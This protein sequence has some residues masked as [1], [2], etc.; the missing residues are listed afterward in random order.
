[1][2]PLEERLQLSTVNPTAVTLGAGSA[3]DLTRTQTLPLSITLPPSSVTN[4][5]DIALLL[6][7]T[8]SFKQFAGTV[9]SLFSNL[10]SS[11]Q[12]A[13]PGVDLGFGIARFEDYGGP[14]SSVTTENTGGRPFFLDRPIV[15]AAT[16]T[17]AGTDLNT[18]MKNALAATGPGFGG[19]TPEP[20]FEAL[21]Q[22]ATGAGFDGNG[23]GSRLDSGL[24]GD[25]ATSEVNPGSSGD[26]PPFSSNV[27]LT[28]G[29]LGGIGWRPGAEHIVL[30]ATDTAPVAS[31]ATSPIPATVTGLGGVS[32]PSTAFESTAGRVGFDSTVVDGV[33]TGPQPAVEPLGGATVQETVNSL[34]SLGI[35]VIGMG[36][37]AAP[38]SSTAAALDPSTFFSAIGR[39]TGTVD[40]TGQPL[41]FSTSVSTSDL[42]TAIVNSVKTVA[43]QPVDIS[44]SPDSLPAGLS[45][46]PAP[47]VVPKVGPGGTAT[48][49]VT[50]AVGSLP[51]TGTF[52]ASFVDPASGTALG[53]VPFQISLPGPPSQGG[54]PGAPT[55]GDPPGDP[56]S[57]PPKVLSGQRVG[58]HM[59]PA[60]IIITYSEAMDPATVQNVN[61]YVLKGPHG[62][63]VAI[64]SASYDS[65]AHTVTLKPKKHVDFH[66]YYS[67]TINGVGAS[68]VTSAAGVPLD[69]MKTGQPGDSYA[70][71]L[72]FYWLYQELPVQA[73]KAGLT[74]KGTSVDLPR[75]TRPR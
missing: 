70:G 47:G 4:K 34:N 50:L 69:G 25:L 71:K 62:G 56:I 29:S 32:V 12:A 14:F 66:V 26:V 60:S 49:N 55:A 57:V 1:M 51:F 45:F 68:A 59:H 19:D 64:V 44:L 41:V 31:F 37:G 30:V 43:T 52:N 13:L 48:F 39:L 35:H 5:V 3:L 17:A 11:L 18:L 10:V 24:A 40:A 6:D 20:D 42:T 2:E 58:V 21:F 28:S 7:D 27:G 36:P 54:L 33:G 22:L 65:A 74:R 38:T 75:R 46:T 53:T 8:G 73:A 23:N 15:T 16:A 61:N 67:L 9:E 72:R 63:V